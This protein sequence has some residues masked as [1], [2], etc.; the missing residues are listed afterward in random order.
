MTVNTISRRDLELLVIGLAP[1]DQPTG[2]LGG[3][4]RLQKYLFLLE[5]EGGV[6]AS[7]DGFTFEPYKAGPYSAKVYDDLEFLENLGLL[8]SEV[9][10][11]ATE[12]EQPDLERLTFDQ[13]FG[14]DKDDDTASADSYEERQFSLTKKGIDQIKRLL[15]DPNFKPVVDGIR[16]IKSRYG[17]YSLSDLLY[18]VYTKYPE[19]ATESEIR[20]KVLRRGRAG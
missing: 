2:S 17:N 6:T 10:A 4:T 16:R 15:V 5:K 12:W 19:M 13:L 1:D 9:T 3:I 7:G 20:N 18:Y 11:E 8:R 14:T